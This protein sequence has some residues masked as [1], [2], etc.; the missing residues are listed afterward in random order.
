MCSTSCNLAFIAAPS[1]TFQFLPTH[2][3][4]E[5]RLPGTPEFAL[6]PATLRR[7]DTSA[8]SINEWTG[9]V[10]AMAGVMQG[11]DVSAVLGVFK[12]L[13]EGAG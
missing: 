11:A 5:C 4:W 8:S 13:Q 12:D 6:T 10:E 3:I 1:C 9:T 2:T 7:N